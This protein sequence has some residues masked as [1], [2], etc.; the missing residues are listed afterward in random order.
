MS[1]L[2]V[3]KFT[4]RAELLCDMA[5][6][7]FCRIYKQKSDL[8]N[9][10]TKFQCLKNPDWQKIKQKL[11]KSFPEV[12]DMTKVTGYDMIS[13]SQSVINTINELTPFMDLLMDIT[14]FLSLSGIMIVDLP[15]QVTELTLSFN[16]N[17]CMLYLNLLRA[18]IQCYMLLASITE[19]KVLLVV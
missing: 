4:E 1:N 5:N 17:I 18:H 3:I 11:E 7:L 12:L 19:K 14:D 2:N 8:N 9:N 6:G 10:I 13:E 15:T 16:R